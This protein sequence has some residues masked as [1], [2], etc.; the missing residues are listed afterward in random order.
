MQ[1]NQIITLLLMLSL[2]TFQAQTKVISHKSHSGSKQTFQNAYTKNLF[3]IRYS[4]FGAP[5]ARPVTVLEKV[6]VLNK[7]KVVLHYKKSK[8]CVIY[9]KNYKDLAEKDFKIVTDTLIN[10]QILNK[11][12]TIDFIKSKKNELSIHF[13][14]AIE[15]VQFIGFRK[16]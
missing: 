8:I 6:T 13:D 11:K 7:N 10:H 15:E 2:T 14:N 12:N 16:K 1:T 3:D 4:N 5:S 9:G